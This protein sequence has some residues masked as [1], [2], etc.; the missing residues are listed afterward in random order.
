MNVIAA[1]AED[2]LV[3]V[4]VT[5]LGFARDDAFQPCCCRSHR[6]ILP[7]E[8]AILPWRGAS[9]HRFR[10]GAAGK[11]RETHQKVLPLHPEDLPV[12]AEIDGED[13]AGTARL[14]ACDLE[15]RG[16]AFGRA[17]I[18][19]ESG[20]RIARTRFGIRASPERIRALIIV[21]CEQGKKLAH[22]TL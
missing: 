17:P 20:K 6:M 16:I 3:S 5:N 1:V 13:H 15:L 22:D 14:A 11:R 4:Y 21:R 9:Q 18:F 10:V 7:S 12:V 8:F 19:H 2:A